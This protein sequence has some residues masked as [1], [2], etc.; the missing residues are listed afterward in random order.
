[1]IRAV[2]AGPP[3]GDTRAIQE[4]LALKTAWR[5]TPYLE[6]LL[7]EAMTQFLG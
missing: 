6:E 4:Y 5:V 1:M 2:K 3:G 7:G